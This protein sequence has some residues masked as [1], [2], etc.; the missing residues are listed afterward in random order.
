M[1]FIMRRNKQD[2]L[3]DLPEKIIQDYLCDL[4]EVQKELYQQFEEIDL[5]HVESDLE[6][7]KGQLEGSTVASNT[8]GPE[9]ANLEM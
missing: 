7:L 3:Q 6:C 8:A 1:P 4:T 2:V 5:K 9:T